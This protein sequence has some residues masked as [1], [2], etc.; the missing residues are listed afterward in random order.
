VPRKAFLKNQRDNWRFVGQNPKAVGIIACWCST[1]GDMLFELAVVLHLIYA[2]QEL[3]SA[4]LKAYN[5]RSGGV[6]LP[7]KTASRA[8]D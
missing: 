2:V 4:I 1:T 5:L 7:S 3:L 8:R 6:K